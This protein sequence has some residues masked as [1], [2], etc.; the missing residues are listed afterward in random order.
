MS[1]REERVFIYR[2]KI[3]GYFRINTFLKI[4]QE[5]SGYPEWCKT[6]QDKDQYINDYE[7]FEGIKLEKNKICVNEGLRSISKLLLNSMWGRYCLQTNKI[8]YS[9]ISNLKDLYSYLLNDLYEIQ[10]IHFLN[11]CKAQLFYSEKEQLHLGGKDSNIDLGA[12]VT[13]Y[14]RFKLNEDVKFNR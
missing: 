14:G 6:E 2:L 3:L 13:C 7:K 9:M 10:D 1:T 4:V 11:D 5:N 8:K 12:F